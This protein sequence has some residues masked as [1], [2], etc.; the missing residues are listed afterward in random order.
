MAHG[1]QLAVGEE[2]SMIVEP[3]SKIRVKYQAPDLEFHPHS[4]LLAQLIDSQSDLV[5]EPEPGPDLV[6]NN[7]QWPIHTILLIVRGD[8]EDRLA[9][10]WAF[11]LASTCRA[12][13]YTLTMTLDAPNFYNRWPNL[14]QDIHLLLLTD[15]YPGRQLRNILDRMNL[16]DIEG[17]IQ[18]R[19]EPPDEQIRLE[20]DAHNPDLLVI[21]KEPHNRLWR[22]LFGEIVRP[23]LRQ[24]D[25]PVLVV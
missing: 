20:M 17:D 3:V 7:P 16:L 14:Q 4:N 25:R 19:S 21:S 5:E 23:L 22:L 18:I 12:R 1:I 8:I 2:E 13:L 10:D 6:I 24:V 11:R 9:I 15:A